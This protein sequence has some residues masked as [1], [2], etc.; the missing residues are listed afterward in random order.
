[1]INNLY[2]W[3]NGIGLTFGLTIISLLIG[4]IISILITILNFLRIRSLRSLINSIVFIIKGTPMLVQIFLIYYGIPQLVFIKNSILWILFKEPFSCACLALSINSAAYM[5]CI[6]I[7]SINLIPE[8]YILSAKSLG[9]SNLI[10]IKR[11]IFPLT[12]KE[13]F[14]A[15]ANE[16]TILLKAT[17]ITSSITLM[18]VAGVAKKNINE[19]YNIFQN[20]FIISIIYIILNKILDAIFEIIKKTI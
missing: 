12:F 16:A 14:P 18:E 19:S 4:A 9:M 20:L 11:I 6:L 7:N 8:K 17:A 2:I 3:I 5:S 15:F 13:V 1:M 10:I